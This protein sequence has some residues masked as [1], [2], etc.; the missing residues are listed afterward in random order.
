MKAGNQGN[1]TRGLVRI[2]AKQRAVLRN[3]IKEIRFGDATVKR[4]LLYI[5]AL[6]ARI[7]QIATQ[8]EQL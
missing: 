1:N 5:D 3:E 6:K 8:M 4:P 2:L 7:E